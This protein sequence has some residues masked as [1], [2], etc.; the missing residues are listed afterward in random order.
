MTVELWE[1]TDLSGCIKSGKIL[2]QERK[3]PKCQ[4]W[5]TG[6]EIDYS[7]YI[8]IEDV[9]TSSGITDT[10][11]IFEGFVDDYDGKTLNHVKLKSIYSED[12]EKV[13]P[14]GN[15]KGTIDAV[16]SGIVRDWCNW[17]NCNSTTLSSGNYQMT[18]E[19]S[20]SQDLPSILDDLVETEGWS[21]YLHNQSGTLWMGDY[22]V[23]SLITFSGTAK[24]YAEDK[25]QDKHKNKVDY[26][27]GISGGEKLYSTTGDVADQSVYGIMPH[28]ED[29]PLIQDQG[30]LDSGALNLLDVV[31]NPPLRYQLFDAC[32]DTGMLQVGEKSTFDGHI[33]VRGYKQYMTTGT[34]YLNRSEYD[35]KSRT[36]KLWVSSGALGKKPATDQYNA[37]R[38]D[39]LNKG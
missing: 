18:G 38:I 26:W 21:W 20:G 31:K 1:Y 11:V 13:F 27:G 10:G 16:A 5:V 39:Q 30:L 15:Y 19:F 3:Y 37:V 24:I 17:I 29:N 32:R 22:P 35:I 4:L 6:F 7:Q 14:T 28:K 2:T 36:S 23:D 8:K 25:K 12:L 9:F 34:Y 33:R